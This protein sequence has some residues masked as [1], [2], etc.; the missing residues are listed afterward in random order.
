MWNPEEIKKKAQKDY[1]R[2][3]LKTTKLLTRTGRKIEW[4]KA[5]GKTHPVEELAQKI[6]GV[7]LAYGF[8]EVINPSMVSEDDVRKQYG[9]EAAVILDRVFY[10]A[11]LPRPDIGLSQKKISQIQQ[12]VPDFSNDK[13]KALQKI[14]REYKEGKIEGDDLVEE[15]VNRLSVETEHA[16]AVISLFPELTK[17]TPIPSKLTLRSHMTALWFPVLATLQYKKSLPMKLFSIGTKYRREQRLDETHLYE[18]LVASMVVMAEEITL[19]DGVELCKTILAELGFKNVKFEEKK[20]TSK[21]YAP[22]MEIEVFVKEGEQWIEVG[23]VGLYSPVSLS[24][25]N[26]HYPVFNAGFGVERIAMI[27]QGAKD[28]RS[29]T[30]PQFYA[31]WTLSDAEIAKMVEIELKPKSREGLKI[32][33][34]IKSTALKY[35]DESS[36][37][38]FTA[39]EGKLHG[40]KVKVYVYETDVG[41]KLLG[42]AARNQIYINNGNILGIPEKGMETVQ[43]VKEAH[44]K[45]VSV[46][47]SYLD[48]V[49]SLAAAKIEEAIQ[50]GR[51]V[52]D[53]R[54]KMA[55][56][57]SDVN[58]K[59]SDVARRYITSQK[60]KIEVVGPVFIGVRAKI[61]D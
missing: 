14:F 37:C 27:L 15:M 58:I 51:K 56:H 59:V 48:A 36:P 23:D 54:V 24:Q 38:E 57:P 9:P 21:Y 40:K 39:Y 34:E 47:F 16:T 42:P 4:K 60:K 55:K 46:R 11:G 20:A 25:Y 5:K 26:I 32:Q 29:L 41:T 22:K 30:Y 3:W 44:E 50:L 2:A 8:D 17:L 10:L 19:E 35:A 43:A 53:I 33:E 1:E 28:I 49:A 18:S 61:V 6:R 45:G 12:V 13:V 7:L 31:E 52:V